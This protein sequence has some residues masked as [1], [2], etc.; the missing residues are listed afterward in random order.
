M[1]K[2]GGWIQTYSGIQFYPLKPELD[3]LNII[4][5]AHALSLVGRYNGHIN[6]HYSIAQH[7][8]LISRTFDDPIL[9]KWGLLHDAPEAYICDIPRPIKPLLIGY[10]ELEET[11]ERLVAEKWDLPFPIPKEVMKHDMQILSTEMHSM[12]TCNKNTEAF[13][14]GISPL[15]VEIEK[16]QPVEA[17]VMFL[18]H[19]IKLFGE[20]M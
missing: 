19:Y 16:L 15:D 3:K 8:V 7:S 4:D 12:M 5:I 6:H 11:Y 9:A 18:Q 10:K 14:Q 13:L 20:N 17:E 2:K 1:P